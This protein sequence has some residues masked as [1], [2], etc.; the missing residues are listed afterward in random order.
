MA[1]RRRIG[2]SI[3][4]TEAARRAL[5]QPVPCWEKVWATPDNAAP[6]SSLRVYRWVK[7]EK[8][9]QFS[10]D[11]D[12]VDVPLAPLPDEIEVVEGDEDDQ[13]EAG[14][15]ADQG[16]T[17]EVPD[18]NTVNTEAF[19]TEALPTP[20][21]PLSPSP[22]SPPPDVHS[23]NP[24]TLSFQPDHGQA[25][26]EEAHDA[27][28]AALKPLDT[29]M[30]SIVDVGGQMDPQ[31]VDVTDL[32]INMSNLGPDGLPMES[33]AHGLSQVVEADDALLGGAMMDSSL[34]PFAGQQLTDIQ[35]IPQ[36]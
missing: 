4:T 13:D 36:E 18:T 31:G 35:D 26:L 32:D 23:P 34:D 33:S 24:H 3:A 15:S 14:P 7:T 6:G 20:A 19:N 5:M 2:V 29:G 30:D 27:L 17:Q 12:E 28:D 21:Q 25:T 10:D 9:Q 8:Q 11:E 22:P 1:T 16:S